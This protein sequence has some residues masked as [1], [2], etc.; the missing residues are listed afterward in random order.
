M[1]SMCPEGPT[2]WDR[3]RVVSPWPQPSSRT[4]EPGRME[5]EERRVR[6]W[7][8]W[9]WRLGE[10]VVGSG[11]D[12]RKHWAMEEM[13]SVEI[14]DIVMVWVLGIDR[15]MFDGDYDWL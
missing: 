13:T 10:D 11:R 5:K 9:A 8:I 1:A 2:R 7:V 12:S 15:G 14:V 6:R 4:R 3:Q